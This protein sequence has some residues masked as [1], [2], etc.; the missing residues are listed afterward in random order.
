M[1][2]KLIIFDCDGVL[3]DSVAIERDTLIIMATELGVLINNDR[4]ITQFQGGSIKETVAFIE[5][6]LGHAVPDDFIPDFRQ[7]SYA[8]YDRD[9]QLIPGVEQML[10]E[11]SL[12]YCVATSGPVEKIRRN[13][14]TTGLLSKFEGKIFSCYDIQRWK[15]NPDIFLYAAKGM[16]VEPERCLV[17]EDSA[18]GIKAGLAA[19]M[20]VLGYPGTESV[21]A[22]EMIGATVFQH[23]HELPALVETISSYG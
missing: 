21:A 11:I 10:D 6:K 12:P 7:R 8:A 13:L 5:T 22:L 15:P 9:L 3:V 4:D 20:T 18:L 2:F 1:E 19:G 16:G 17:V 23:M 14:A